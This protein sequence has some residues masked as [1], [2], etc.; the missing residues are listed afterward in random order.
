MVGNF[1]SNLILQHVH[2]EYGYRF[3]SYSM[4]CFTESLSILYSE[5]PLYILDTLGT[6]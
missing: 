5:T 6:A 4:Q 3:A 2:G 1:A